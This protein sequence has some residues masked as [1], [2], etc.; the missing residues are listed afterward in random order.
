M[1]CIF[2]FMM[3]EIICCAERQ[4]M[5]MEIERFIINIPMTV[6]AE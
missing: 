5:K 4:L 1:M 3:K 6:R 2:V